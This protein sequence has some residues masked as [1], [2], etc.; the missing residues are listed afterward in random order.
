MKPAATVKNTTDVPT[1]SITC[2]ATRNPSGAAIV[3]SAMI[4][5]IALGRISGV[6]RDVST[7]MTGPF[8]S[9]V[10][11]VAENSASVNTQAG[12]SIPSS[13]SGS[14]TPRIAAAARRRGCVRGMSITAKIV[15]INA[16]APSAL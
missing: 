16:P 3:F 6:I 8:T 14:V 1:R 15:P 11:N 10:N 9:G 13:Q 4:A 7:P 12:R 5:V 2:P